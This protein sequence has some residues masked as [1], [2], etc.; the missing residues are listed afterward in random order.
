MDQN[1][2]TLPRRARDYRQMAWTAL[3]GVWGI[4][5]VVALVAGLL[6]GAGVSF[7]TSFNVNINGNE[8]DMPSAMQ[9]MQ[10]LMSSPAFVAL[11]TIGSLLALVSFV[12]GGP[13]RVGYARFCMK[14]T[15]GE[16][17]EFKD[18]FSGF[19]VFGE[20]FLLNL[21]IALRIIGWTLLFII[22]GIIAAFRYA[23]AFNVMAENP[24]LGS[25]ECIERS[26]VMMKGNKWK[27]FCLGFSFIGWFFLTILTL[28]IAG[29]WLSPY[30]AVA[31]MFFYHDVKYLAQL[32]NP[33][34][35]QPVYGQQ[36]QAQ[37]Q[38]AQQPYGQQ[39]YD[40]QQYA[41]QPQQPQQPQQ[42]NDGNWQ[43]W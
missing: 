12:I 13:I 3:K 28:G 14:I 9:T 24:G 43:N 38:Y 2:V 40:P 33:Q 36:Y 42:G 29:L 23:M 7:N 6:S 11:S 19:D 25:G 34:W 15:R 27:L 21:R 41:Q 32:S 20:A 22:P 16:P 17:V 31:E 5:I 18:L 37:Q 10:S 30:M 39:Y 4:A 26:K 8:M 35:Q 1:Y